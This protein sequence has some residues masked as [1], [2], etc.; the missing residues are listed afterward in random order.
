MFQAISN[1]FQQFVSSIQEEWILPN[2]T[3]MERPGGLER[4][5]FHSCPSMREFNAL[6]GPNTRTLNIHGPSQQIFTEICKLNNLVSLSVVDNGNS[7]ITKIPRLPENLQQLTLD[8]FPHIT[9]LPKLPSHL[10]CLTLWRFPRVEVIPT[11]PRNLHQL[12][13]NYFPFVSTLPE[14]PK[15]I[16]R[17]TLQKFPLLK[18]IPTLPP[19]VKHVTLRGHVATTIPEI[20]KS[21]SEL[22]LLRFP[23]VTVLP[24]IPCE[25]AVIYGFRY[26]ANVR[27]MPC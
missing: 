21:V 13:L 12:T 4:V 10:Q 8:N 1:K 18:T 3:E 24:E 5:E 11:L 2:I 17:L 16:Q 19:H 26:I 22:V 27:K 7:Q 15:N 25:N 23:N 9:K 6:V 14:L 20:P